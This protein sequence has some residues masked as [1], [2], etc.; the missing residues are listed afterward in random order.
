MA[1]VQRQ[2]ET[3]NDKIKLRRYYEDAT[4]VEKRDR[5]LRTLRDGIERLRKEGKPIPA[6]WT[7]NQGSY[8]IGVGV[9][10]LDGDYDIDVGVAFDLARGDHNPVAV[11]QWVLEAV[12][13]HTSRVEMRSSCVTVFYQ[14]AGEPMYHV[15][16]AVYADKP[17]NEQKMYLARGK[18]T[19]DAESRVW[20][21]ADPEGLTALLNDRFSGDDAKQFRRNIRALKRFKDHRFASAG[22][23]APRGIALAVAAF[24]WFAPATRLVDGKVERDDLQSLRNLVGAML[25]RFTPRLAVSC[26]A[27]PFDN[28]CS[29]MSDVQMGEFKV[30]LETLLDALREAADD[31]D[32]HTACKTLA[33]QFGDDF[34]IPE[35]A[36]T[37]RPQRRAVTS[38]GSSG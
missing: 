14:A 6:Y 9:K 18:A 32:P 26:P 2:F 19:S 36:A 22:H 17:Q 11:K 27:E 20:S 35:P 4:L 5:V 25:L 7:F 23:A 34:P 16:L 37:A 12:D 21:P 24:H 33:R 38:S 30:K 15:D 10:P 1:N 31:A 13:G 29:R 28:L 3:F 8:E